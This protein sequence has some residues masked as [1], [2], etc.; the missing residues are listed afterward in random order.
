MESLLLAVAVFGGGCFWCVESEFRAYMD[1]GVVH[2]EVGYAGGHVEH[3]TY[4][5]IIQK[6]TGHTEVVRVTFDPTQISYEQLLD[7]FFNAHDPTQLNRQGPDV[8]FAYRSVIFY[9]NETQREVAQ[10]KITQLTATKAYHRPIVTVV[11]ALN[12]NYYR[13]EDYH[14]QYEEK[15]PRRKIM[16]D[17]W[18]VRHDPCKGKVNC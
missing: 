11:D 10:Q 14:Q 1:Q 16:R 13:A 7:V 12:G 5:Q 6:N 17:A 15:N 2:T 3:P 18:D 8:G 9:T 4:E